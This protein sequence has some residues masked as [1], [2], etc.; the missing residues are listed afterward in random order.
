MSKRNRQPAPGA[1]GGRARSAPVTVKKPFPWGTVI[2]SVVLGALLI[3]LVAYA[4]MNQGSGVRDL[5]AEDDASFDGIELVENPARDHVSGQVDYPDYPSVPPAGGEHNAV[6]Q[7]CAVYDEEISPEHAVHALEHGAVWITYAPDLDESQV[8]DLSSLVDGDPYRLMSPL[9]GQESPI[10][11]SAW[12]R[13]LQISDAGDRRVNRF[14]D[15]YTNGRQTP[16]RG[17]ACVGV[18]TTGRAPVGADP[19]QPGFMPEPVPADE[20]VNEDDQV[21]PEDAPASE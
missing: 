10:V 20:E 19:S 4:A 9:P 18:S 11:L 7:Q 14:L 5:L 21:L 17:A 15:V 12:G 6:P 3:G 2:A 8:E 16:E 1:A 13:Q